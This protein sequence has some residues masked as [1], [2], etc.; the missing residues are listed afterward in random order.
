[1]LTSKDILER[2]GISRATLNNYIAGGL[3]ARPEV[4]QPSRE[5][6]DAPRIGYFPDDTVERIAT[7]QRLKQQ[8]WS[9][10]RIAEHFSRPAAAAAAPS[11]EPGPAERQAPAPSA[12]RGPP[13]LTQL[14]VV[15]AT[16]HD[17]PGWWLRLPAEEYFELL[18][19]VWTALEPIFRRRQGVLGRH[20]DEG[21]VAYFSAGTAASQAWNAVTAAEEARAAMQGLSRRWRAAKGWDVELQMAIGI[22]AGE[23]WMGATAAGELR[24]LGEAAE[25]AEQISRCSRAGAVVATRRVLA[26]LAPDARR[27]V[28]Y[29]A[30]RGQAEGH[31]L[32]TFGR[33]G[34]FFA[35][36]GVPPR[37][38]ELAVAE[39]LQVKT[40]AAGPA[41]AG[42]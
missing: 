36:A 9:I 39:I 20:P 29:G 30:P 10:G 11:P 4:L 37:F 3:I 34:D 17:R 42:L 12:L 26:K 31:V 35:P 1:M 6:G 19:E 32:A 2:T 40:D 15:V 22:D 24:V 18:G 21:L 7:I 5:D 25:R 27:L 8:G 23:D 16:L 28:V 38:A 13:V 33:L 41:A 14:A